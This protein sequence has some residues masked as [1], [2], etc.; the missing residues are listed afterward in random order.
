MNT[1]KDL[2][3]VGIEAMAN[4]LPEAFQLTGRLYRRES[5]VGEPLIASEVLL[6]KSEIGLEE[7]DLWLPESLI[8]RAEFTVTEAEGESV[9]TL[10]EQ[11]LCSAEDIEIDY[12]DDFVLRSFRT[13]L[14]KTRTKSC[15]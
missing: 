11:A 5:Q 13:H 4:S 9:I 6:R 8:Q 15:N 2:L 3:E 10:G 12:F 14:Q 1:Y 7:I